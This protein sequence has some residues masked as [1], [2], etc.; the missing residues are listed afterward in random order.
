MAAEFG[1]TLDQVNW[2]GNIVAVIYMP[3]AI[4]VPIIVSQYGIRRCVCFFV[5]LFWHD[6]ISP[7]NSPQCDVG[8]VT[9]LIS[10][11]IR[12]AGIIPSLPVNG[13]YALLFLG[14]VLLS[15]LTFRILAS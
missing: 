5:G 12:Y 11:W 1:I 7:I 8:A 14:Q 6:H 4:L 3:A 13:A 10:A 9:L 15:L 2:L